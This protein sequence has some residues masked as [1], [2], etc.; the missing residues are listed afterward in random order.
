LFVLNP[1]H[2]WADV[3]EGRNAPPSNG[4]NSAATVGKADRMNMNPDAARA[5]FEE[6]MKRSQVIDEKNK[7]LLTV[8]ALLLAACAAVA[9]ASEPTW[10]VL[11]TLLLILASIYL[12]LVHFGVQ[13]ISIPAYELANDEERIASFCKCKESLASANE[14]RVGIY[15]ASCRA[16]TLGVFLFAVILICW[17]FTERP[18]A[19]DELVKSVRGSLELQGLLRGPQGP[20]GPKGESGAEGPRGIQGPPGPEGAPGRV[21]VIP[22]TLLNT[23]MLETESMEEGD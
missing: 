13:T 16:A 1:G 12:V 4:D 3:K 15:R 22:Q 9:S 11:G 18:S 7:V 19:Q 5:Y 23:E 2:T 8:A 17:A 20:I 6:E 21:V 10:L 14:Y